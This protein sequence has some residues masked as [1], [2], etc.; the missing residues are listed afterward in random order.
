MKKQLFLVLFAIGAFDQTYAMKD[1]SASISI[2]NMRPAKKAAVDRL[3]EMTFNKDLVFTSTRRAKTKDLVLTS[4]RAALDNLKGSSLTADQL[5]ILPEM[6]A[7]VGNCLEKM[8][9]ET[10]SE[11]NI[12]KTKELY[13]KIYTEQEIEEQIKFYDSAV[14]QKVL[15][16][17]PE[18]SDQ[19]TT[20]M[21]E[22]M[23]KQLNDL[24]IEI[25]KLVDK[26]ISQA[27]Q[28]AQ[29]QKGTTAK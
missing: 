3:L 16:N 15:K 10:F 14:G 5:L 19:I 23:Q 2:A 11:S 7:L 12:K 29:V 22:T 26:Q 21:V 27:T 8:E 24:A 13:T 28:K 4:M 1:K 9:Q 20:I 17:L 18:V 6:D 25:T